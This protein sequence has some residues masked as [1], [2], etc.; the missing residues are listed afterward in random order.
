MIQCSPYPATRPQ[1]NQ[2]IVEVL[3]DGNDD[4]N[5]KNGEEKAECVLLILQKGKEKK[6]D[7]GDMVSRY[8]KH[9]YH[10]QN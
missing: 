2:Q 9:R 4:K 5:V 7:R 1:E 3:R 8:W 6:E 10:A